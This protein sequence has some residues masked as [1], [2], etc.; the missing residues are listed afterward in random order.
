MDRLNINPIKKR[1]TMKE[2][3][4]DEIKSAILTGQLDKKEYYP[5]TLLAETLNTSRT[6][7]R[8]AANELV[9]E[10]L[11]LVYPRKGYK[12]K[13]I[14]ADEREQI[15]YLRTCIEKKALEVLHSK[16]T[17]DQLSELDEIIEKQ[18]EAMEVEDRYVFIEYDQKMHA[19]FVQMAELNIMEDIF[20][21][22]YNLMRLIG[23]TALM[24]QGRMKEVI[25]EHKQVVQALRD[26]NYDEASGNLLS[27]LTNTHQIVQTI[28]DTKTN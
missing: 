15:V 23:H 11:L 25:E 19:T 22:I 4:Y 3:A 13:E 8:E 17:E 2:I 9:A 27:H 18:R 6:P 26:G 5:E 12:V 20:Q 1:Q 24:K 21:K 7:V 14:S 16:I 10:G 28:E